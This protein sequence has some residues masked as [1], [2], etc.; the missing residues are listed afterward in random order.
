SPARPGGHTQLAALDRR[1]GGDELVAPRH[2]VD[3]DL[4]DSR[5]G[6]RGTPLRSDER[7]QV[8]VVVVRGAG[9]LERLGEVGDLLRLV[10]PVPDHVHR[11][12]V[13]GTR[14]QER[15]ERTASV[16]ILARADRHRSPLAYERERWRG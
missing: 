13:E 9:D 7:R 5:V 14:L 15:S 1:G 3:V 12:D 4:E 10:E 16:E 2:V 8:R 11:S 6:D